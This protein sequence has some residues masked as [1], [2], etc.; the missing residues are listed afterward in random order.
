MAFPQFALVRNE[1]GK[2]LYRPRDLRIFL[3]IRELLYD[4]KYTLDTARQELAGEFK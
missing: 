2:R 4:G 3:R 1:D